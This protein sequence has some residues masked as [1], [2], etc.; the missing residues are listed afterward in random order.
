MDSTLL[1]LA[2]KVVIPDVEFF[3]NLGDWPLV[4]KNKK[5]YPIFS[6]CGSEE[7]RDIVLPT[8]DLTESS[9]ENMG[10]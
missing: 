4:P 5:L 1:S 10:R 3:M 9:I 7:T 8:Y 6:W 2:R